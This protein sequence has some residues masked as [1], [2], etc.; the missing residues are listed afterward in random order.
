MEEDKDVADVTDSLFDDSDGLEEA[1]ETN[2]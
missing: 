2:L 1:V